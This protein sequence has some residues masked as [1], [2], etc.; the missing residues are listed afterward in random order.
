MKYLILI[1]FLL[2]AGCRDN[3]NDSAFVKYQVE[4]EGCLVKYID[5]PRGY[6]FFIAKCPAESQTITNQRQSGKSTTTDVTVVTS[7]ELRKQLEK[8]EAK[9]KAMAKLSDEEKKLLGVK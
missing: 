2:L 1:G 5:N 3:S 4:A 7:V 9:E 6:N 8:V